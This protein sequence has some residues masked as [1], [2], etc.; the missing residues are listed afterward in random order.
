MYR[1]N[2]IIIALSIALIFS[3]PSGAQAIRAGF[4]ASP[5]DVGLSV[6]IPSLSPFEFNRISAGAD[7]YGIL[8][9][10]TGIPGA[11]ASYLHDFVFRIIGNE[12]LSASFYAGAGASAGWV[13]DFEPGAFNR[14]ENTLKRDPGLMAALSGN[15][16]CL[17]TFPGR[18]ISVCVDFTGSFGALT[19]RDNDNGSLLLSL[20][21]NGIYRAL[22]PHIIIM[23]DL[24]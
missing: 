1:T 9:G 2:R 16:G 10:R 21:H 11:S 18:N 20:Y 15:I 13:R 14:L 19:K 23:L 5:A 17:L 22:Y 6:Y 3:V 24:R 7:L 8:L 4:S 12:D